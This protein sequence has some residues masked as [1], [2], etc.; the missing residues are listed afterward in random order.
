[1]L[2]P[3]ISIIIPAY[4]EAQRLP[5][6]LAL[7]RDYLE[8]KD[9]VAEVLVVDDASQDETVAVVQAIQKRF[10]QLKIVENMVNKGKGGVVK[11]GMLQAIGTWRLFIDADNSTPIQELNKF[12]LVTEGKA[13]TVGAVRRSAAQKA[14]I[15]HELPEVVIGSRYLRADSIKIKQPWKR[16]VL[17][18]ISNWFIQRTVLPGIQDTQCGFKL[19]SAKATKEIFPQLTLTGWAFDVELLTIAWY[20]GYNIYEVPV[21]WFDARRSKLRAIKAVSQ[22]SKDL[23]RVWLKVRRHQYSREF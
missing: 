23:W 4:N 2:E 10:K 7:V 3:Y 12:L 15:S 20:L 13:V 14:L 17:S 11:Q 19:F 22:S 1:M 8:E 18:R 5:E 16:R 6:T 21:D 9:F